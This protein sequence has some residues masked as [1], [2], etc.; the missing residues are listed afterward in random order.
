MKNS[1]LIEQKSFRRYNLRNYKNTIIEMPSSNEVS[2]DESNRTITPC[3]NAEEELRQHVKQLQLALASSEQEK[4]NLQNIISRQQNEN[5]HN[6][7]NGQ[8]TEA[9][10]ANISVVS[11]VADITST[12]ASYA[13][14]S[15]SSKIYNTITSTNNAASAYVNSAANATPSVYAARTPYV[16]SHVS[17][18]NPIV[19]YNQLPA[20]LGVHPP[21]RKV[22]DLPEFHGSPEEW[23]MFSVAYKETTRLYAYTDLENL[24]RLQKALKTKAR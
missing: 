1:S 15:K 11:T 7:S 17:S 4:V 24:L 21:I 2:D 14:S 23:P 8:S 6:V 10:P 18:I 20:S 3:K 19:N 22:L 5:V 13:T 9:A 12:T 16:S